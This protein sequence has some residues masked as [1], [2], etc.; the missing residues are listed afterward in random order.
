MRY[1][2]V[3]VVVIQ[4]GFRSTTGTVV[5][6]VLLMVMTIFVLNAIQETSSRLAWSFARDNGLIFSSK[7][8]QMH[9]RLEVPVWSLL[10]T[11]FLLVVCGCIFV[12]SKTGAYF[13]FHTFSLTFTNSDIQH[14]M[15]SSALQS[16]CKRFHSLF[17][18]HCWYTERGAPSIC[19]KHDDSNFHHRWDGPPIL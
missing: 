17:P 13:H 9:P 16:S 15:P 3:P 12:A 4:Q 1:R 19:R 2:F 14:L 6:V 18:S 5:Y 8:A 10:L 11:W 7:L